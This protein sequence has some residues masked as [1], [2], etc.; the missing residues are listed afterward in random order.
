[1]R[2]T[3]DARFSDAD[4]ARATAARLA[5]KQPAPEERVPSGE[6]LPRFGTSA[7]PER[8]LGTTRD[9]PRLLDEVMRRAAGSA[10]FLSDRAGLLIASGGDLPRED[11]EAVAARFALAADQAARITDDGRTGEIFVSVERGTWVC[12]WF[13]TAYGELIVG[14]LSQSQSP[15]LLVPPSQLAAM[16]G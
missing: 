11:L 6:V 15:T 14:C 8:P 9:W 7:A 4:A 3:N 16:A 5:S 1:M 10:A 2:S 13:S 12:Q